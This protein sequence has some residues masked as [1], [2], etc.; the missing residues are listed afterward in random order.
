MGKVKERHMDGRLTISKVHSNQEPYEW[1]RIQVQDATSDTT[2]LTVEVSLLEFMKTLTGSSERACTFELRAQQVGKVYEHK[3]E[4]VPH[5]GGGVD[6]KARAAVALE[7]FE[8]EGWKGRVSDY[9]NHHRYETRNGIT[10]FNVLFTRYVKKEQADAAHS[11][12]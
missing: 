5:Q 4:F 12:Q 10:G 11:R 7:P 9:G 2:F 8:V 6:Y 1:M 3:V